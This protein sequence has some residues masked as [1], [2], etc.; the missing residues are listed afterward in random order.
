MG[1]VAGRLGSGG[2]AHVRHCLV[3]NSSSGASHSVATNPGQ[4]QHASAFSMR[5]PLTSQ[6][7]R[8]VGGDIVSQELQP[9]KANNAVISPG[10]ACRVR[11]GPDTTICA[12]SSGQNPTVSTS[13]GGAANN[14]PCRSINGNLLCAPARPAAFDGGPPPNPR[15][16][17]QQGWL[18]PRGNTQ[19]L[20]LAKEC[21]M[22]GC[23]WHALAASSRRRNVQTFKTAQEQLKP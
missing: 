8:L 10:G 6:D 1:R 2:A 4:Q 7:H 15:P 21:S 22:A 23:N 16:G 17:L 19:R 18:Q 9:G 13:H 14:M 5:T 3:W 12:T 20:T 11:S